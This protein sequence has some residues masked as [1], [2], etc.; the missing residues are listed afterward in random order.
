MSAT[1]VPSNRT[2]ATLLAFPVGSK[3]TGRTKQKGTDKISHA[4]RSP[5]K[6]DTTYGRDF[7]PLFVIVKLMGVIHDWAIRI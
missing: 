1:G 3:R 7:L 2:A 6:G 5:P 4:S